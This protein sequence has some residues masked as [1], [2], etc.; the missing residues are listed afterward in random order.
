ML[1][2]D[3]IM[4]IESWLC[5]SGAGPNHP[6]YQHL[7]LDLQVT[8]AA[9]SIKSRLRRAGFP[10]GQRLWGTQRQGGMAHVTDCGP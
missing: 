10:T 3:G 9:H 2:W 7:D 1:E 6:E 8:K 4:A 5:R